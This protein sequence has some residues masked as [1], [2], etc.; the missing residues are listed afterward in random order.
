MSAVIL[1]IIIA[2]IGFCGM[3]LLLLALHHSEPRRLD[4][5]LREII[6]REG[7]RTLSRSGQ[8]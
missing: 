1:A 7:R 4:Q 2:A 6:E 3:L 8:D 5:V